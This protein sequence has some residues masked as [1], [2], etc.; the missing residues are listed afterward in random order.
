M[1]GIERELMDAMTPQAVLD[2]LPQGEANGLTVGHLVAAVTGKVHHSLALERHLR[3]VIEAL[4]CNGH[5]VC[6][7]PGRG[8]FLAETNAELEH[9]CEFLYSRAMTSLRQVAAIKRVSLPDLRG[10]LRLPAEEQNP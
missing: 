4:R 2:A 6:A 8:Y 9:T 10:Q 5:P 1:Q 3:R 7:L